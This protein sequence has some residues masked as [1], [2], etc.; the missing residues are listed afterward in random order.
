MSDKKPLV[1]P[2]A[3]Q[4]ANLV[5]ENEPT[6]DYTTKKTQEITRI[7]ED[8]KTETPLDYTN[9]V[10]QMRLRSEQQIN[11]VNTSGS[12]QRSELAEKTVGNRFITQEKSVI[13]D[14]KSKISSISEFIDKK[15]LLVN[16][17]KQNQYMQNNKQPINDDMESINRNYINELSQPNFNSPYDVIPL[18][19]EGKLYKTKKPNIKIGYMT[20]ADENILT[21]PNLITSG[22]FLE[23]LINRKML[24]TDLRY[25]DLHSGDAEAIFLW[26]RA[27]SYGEMYP[28]TILDEN[29]VPFDTEIDL[30]SLKVKKLGAEPDEEGLFDFTLPV[31]KVNIKFK[32]L[33]CGENKKITKMLKLDTENNSP[34]NKEN[35]YKMGYMLVEVDGNRNRQDIND[36]IEK[37]RL[38]DG[39]AFNKYIESIESGIDLHINVRTPG[40]GSVSTFLRYGP[41]FFWPDIQL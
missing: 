8:S 33:T 35:L 9:A 31:S 25:D 13:N 36:Y 37:M 38:A 21:S 39:R 16:N 19:S 5:K 27:T 10:E 26:L 22:E 28:I 24:D 17:T 23:I 40:D 2:S 41:K 7:Y 4:K 15:D 30:N 14:S 32:L 11:E 20:T 1:F 3:E 29:N 34:I 18:P 6:K 12:V